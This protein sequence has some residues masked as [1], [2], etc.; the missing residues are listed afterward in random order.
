MEQIDKILTQAA[1][2]SDA[3]QRELLRQL[4]DSIYYPQYRP[5]PAA[6]PHVAV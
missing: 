2:L 1:A 3:D 6:Q 4:H 5:A